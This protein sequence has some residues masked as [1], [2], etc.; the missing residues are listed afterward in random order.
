MQRNN[1]GSW[2]G[3]AL[4]AASILTA[5]AAP[6]RLVVIKADGLPAEVLDRWARATDPNTGR[7][8]LP[9]VDHVFRRNG[10]WVR[11]FYTRG[12]SLSAPAWSMLDTGEHLVIKGNVEYDRF[13]LRVYDYLN[14]FPFYL[15]NARSTRADM[16]GP[17]VLDETGHSLLVD[18]FPPEERYQSNQLFQRGVHWRILGQGAV[19]RITSRTPRELFDEWQTGFEFTPAV[20]EQVE[21]EVM[22]GIAGATDNYLDYYFIDYDHVVHLAN[23]EASLVGVLRKL[24]ALVG[25]LYTAIEASPRAKDTILVLVS[26]HGMN[27]DADVYSQGYN[28]VQFFNSAKGG[29]HHVVLNR[30][31]MTEYKLRALD[32]FVTEVSSASSESLYLAGQAANYPTALLDLDGNER[33]SI[34]LR[35]SDLNRLQQLLQRA[36]A[37]D[38][39][40][41]RDALALIESKRTAWSRIVTE[42]EE[43][44]AALKRGIERQR[45]VVDAQEKKFNRLEHDLELDEPPKRERAAL[46][47]WE[48]DYEGYGGY[49]EY[50]RH[51]LSLKASDLQAA[52]FRVDQL[53]PRRAMGDANRIC[54]LQNYS[55]GPGVRINYFQALTELRARNNVQQGVSSRPVDFIAVALDPAGL[56]SLNAGA[57][58]GVFLYF[59]DA[60]EALLLVRERAGQVSIRYQPAAK[61][62]QDSNGA[63]TFDARPWGADLPL[64]YFED[65]ALD[66][67]GE[68]GAWLSEW[69]TDQEWLSAVHRTMYSNGVIGLAEH[70]GPTRLG[71]TSKLWDEAG[72]DEPVLRRFE[73]RKR[74]RVATDLLVLAS[75]HWNFNVRGFNP[76][77]NHG[78]FFRVSTNSTLMLSGAGIPQGRQIERPYDSMSFFPTLLRVSGLATSVQVRAYPGRVI[79]E[80]LP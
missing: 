14:F 18:R 40:A 1:R 63:I 39:Q 76:G 65:P 29:G 41:G 20:T 52:K 75:N 69:H 32:P 43:E 36:A 24:D 2:L 62:T 10:S 17:E 67:Q 73:E 4:C 35:N 58:Y 27:S 9:W 57:D 28:L 80:L 68:R 51:L 78:S 15:A 46:S 3:L 61:L 48:R 55:I 8:V 70:F 60:H 11:N 21:R 42:V 54:D 49:V 5:Q 38:M 53:I 13:T 25:R 44:R 7:S 37:K 23:D 31:P 34:H 12:I 72:P 22:Q 79:Q 77:G 33:A 74:G 50:L 16:P 19:K 6:R 47:S 59:D 66:V 64:K 45:L 71:R 26:D 30:H 56:A